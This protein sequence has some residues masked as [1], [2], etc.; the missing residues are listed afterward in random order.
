HVADP[1]LPRVVEQHLRAEDVGED[2]LGR[3]EDGAVDVALRREVDDRLAAFC[4]AHDRLGIGDVALEEVVLDPLEV[5][6]VTRVGQLVED[7]ALAARGA[8]RAREL[9]ADESG[10][11]GDEDAHRLRVVAPD[12]RAAPR[13]SAEAAARPSHCEARNTPAAARARRTPPSR[14]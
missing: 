3:S 5:R 4:R 10:A 1:A 7:G 9:R 8:Q 2:E 12:T 13:A 6:T 11:A 14:C